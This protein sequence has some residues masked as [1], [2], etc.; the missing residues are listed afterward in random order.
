MN[1]PRVSSRPHHLTLEPKLP[2][3]E[4]QSRV[5]AG[6]P[7]LFAA[8]FAALITTNQVSAVAD[9]V[10]YVLPSLAAV[11]CFF[12]YLRHIDWP[13][14]LWWIGFVWLFWSV[15]IIAS[16][17][18][19]FGIMRGI[20]IGTAA[21]LPFAIMSFLP[22]G[23]DRF[24]KWYIGTHAI[25]L[26]T[27]VFYVFTKI[28]RLGPWAIKE[29]GGGGPY[30]ALYGLNVVWP[31]LLAVADQESGYRKLFF[32]IL[33]VLSMVSVCLMF[34]RAC[35]VIM[36]I[37]V[38]VLVAWKFPKSFW[39]VIFCTV[40]AMI[41]LHDRF[42]EFMDW[43]RFTDLESDASR[44]VIWNLVITQLS[45]NILWGVG[46]GNS[47]YYLFAWRPY[48]DAH[49][50]VLQPA[51]EMGIIAGI[52]MMLFVVYA[53]YLIVKLVGMGGTGFY[54]AV[55][56]SAWLANG[57]TESYTYCPHLEMLIAITLVYGKSLLNHRQS[58]V[59]DY[60]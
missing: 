26:N 57:I 56:A 11:L 9:Q 15:S 33:A 53:L 1:V 23:M 59:I 10:S 3:V 44:P 38:M 43:Y 32:Q 27:W 5:D 24:M 42:D 17:E 28:S 20:I 48:G 13:A 37:G 7:G 47:K 14:C 18:A 49:N 58:M 34:S 19:D 36:L 6:S 16:I 40:V 45:H 22:S 41:S 50:M 2:A 54:A 25:I 55:A 12:F 29:Q 46:P 52:L 8:L 21:I 30:E 51:F 39:M 31:L 35:L 4:A 60:S